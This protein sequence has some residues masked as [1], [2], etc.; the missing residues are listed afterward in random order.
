MSR[1]PFSPP[2]ETASSAMTDYRQGERFTSRWL[3]Q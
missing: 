1:E 2:C 3:V